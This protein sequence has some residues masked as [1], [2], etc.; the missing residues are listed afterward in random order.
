MSLF[1]SVKGLLGGALG[2]MEAQLLPELLSK[3]LSATNLG[4]L[5]GLLDRL[6]QSGLEAQ[7]A[8]W[9]GNGPNL[10]VTAEQLE[11]ALGDTV[12]NKISTTLNMP[13]DEVFGLLAQNL[14]ALIDKLSPH[15]KLQQS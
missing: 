10:P 14:P 8:S 11:A 3:A 2:Q 6:K 9:L 5:Q 7:V 13:P 12:V 15:G 4:S 1:D